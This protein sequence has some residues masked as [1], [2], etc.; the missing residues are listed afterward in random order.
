MASDK[1]Q[2]EEQKRRIM[3]AMLD[4]IGITRVES[5]PMEDGGRNHSFKGGP[6]PPAFQDYGFHR[7]KSR[8]PEPEA[9]L[10]MVDVWNA[11]VRTGFNDSDA[12][13]VADLDDLGGPRLYDRRK[14]TSRAEKIRNKTKAIMEDLG[15]RTRRFV[16][17]NARQLDNINSILA[18]SVIQPS[19]PAKGSNGR[20]PNQKSRNRQNLAGDLM[21]AGNQPIRSLGYSSQNNRKPNAHKQ[22]PPPRVPPTAA[23]RPPQPPAVR[24]PSRPAQGHPLPQVTNAPRAAVIHQVQQPSRKTQPV[25][26][27]PPPNAQTSQALP[28]SFLSQASSSP[29]VNLFSHSADSEPNNTIF[30]L[31]VSLADKK[32]QAMGRAEGGLPSWVYLSAAPAPILGLF[33][34]HVLGQ[35]YCEWPIPRWY[36][37]T[38]DSNQLIVEF[39]DTN[40]CG[41]YYGLY[42]NR[43]SDIQDFL[44]CVRELQN[45]EF[46]AD[47]KNMAVEEFVNSRTPAIETPA[48]PVVNIAPPPGLAP[49]PSL[50]PGLAPPPTLSPPPGLTVNP[51]RSGQRL[52]TQSPR[53]QPSGALPEQPRVSNGNNVGNGFGNPETAPNNTTED[54]TEDV[55]GIKSTEDLQVEPQLIEDEI[56]TQAQAEII[57]AKTMKDKLRDF[58]RIFLKVY[59]LGGISGKT[60]KE[61]AE[62][63]EGIKSGMLECLMS[64]DPSEKEML[65]E[66]FR[67][68]FEGPDAEPENVQEEAG[69]S[70]QLALPAKEEA[71]APIDQVPA[72]G[73]RNTYSFDTLISLRQCAKTLP[74]SLARVPIPIRSKNDLK[75]SYHQSSSQPP[76]PGAPVLSDVGKGFSESDA[77]KSTQAMDWVMGKS[78]PSQPSTT[79]TLTQDSPVDTNAPGQQTSTGNANGRPN[80]LRHGPPERPQDKGMS[81]S[82]WATPEAQIKSANQFTGPRYEKYWPKGSYLYDL[83]Q[84]D[85]MANVT[86]NADE[87]GEFFFPPSEKVSQTLGSSSAISATPDKIG[88]LSSGLSQI[89]IL[90]PPTSAL[91]SAPT[92]TVSTP[93]VTVP[94][95]TALTAAARPR[96]RGLGASRHN[97]SG[98]SLG[99]SGNFDFYCPSDKQK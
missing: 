24:A 74:E 85:P 36:N 44:S 23:N 46:A 13:A 9:P 5:L 53:G 67:E 48:T 29:A 58:A 3:Q 30:K 50:T 7:K 73:Y 11:A 56:L 8:V 91:A 40:G 43:M 77:S 10:G 14:D 63:V 2:E 64:F 99:S 31:P 33:T 19:A 61:I 70:V 88:R 16:F 54:V 51:N 89:S 45:G 59:T 17:N 34:L 87:I 1:R 98:T 65:N 39:R 94:T 26:P 68:V 21:P 97:D 35:K 15:P 93:T 12:L 62:T 49:P 60:K 83:A 84:L 71:P 86:A 22:A 25:A 41:I 18:K 57:T 20:P 28:V 4:D 82:R 42:F 75:P 6:P 76:K 38:S 55:I 52:D 81:V 80:Q 92:V 96:F 32:W 37:Y 72:G 66:V 90:E 47:K 69:P 79:D 95:P 27:P 78:Q